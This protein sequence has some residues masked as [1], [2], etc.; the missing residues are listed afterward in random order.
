MLFRRDTL[1]GIAEGRVT[2]A[3]RRWRRGRPR[4]LGGERTESKC[5]E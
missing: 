4:G 3:F 5:K 2:L 1:Q